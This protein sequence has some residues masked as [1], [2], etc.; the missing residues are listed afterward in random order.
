MSLPPRG[1]SCGRTPNIEFAQQSARI[2]LVNR[3]QPDTTAIAPFQDTYTPTG[4][5]KE[6]VPPAASMFWRPLFWASSG[7][8]AIMANYLYFGHFDIALLV[9]PDSASYLEFTPERTAGYPLFLRL[10]SPLYPQS[11]AVAQLNLYLAAVI[12]LGH[13]MLRLF[14][15]PWAAWLVTLMLAGHTSLQ[16]LAMW[17]LSDSLFASLTIAVLAAIAHL[18]MRP[19]TRWAV[20]ASTLCAA[21]ILVR[22]AG[23]YLFGVLIFLSITMPARNIRMQTALWVPVTASLVIASATNMVHFG[24]F[25]PQV[26]GGYSLVGHVAEKIESQPGGVHASLAESIA[27]RLRP[28]LE[29]RPV[30]PYPLGYQE[31]TTAD[32][33]EILWQNVIPEIAAYVAR[34]DPTKDA[35]VAT[36]AV[37]GELAR[38]VIR[39]H[40][41]WY[42][43]HVT[44]HFLGL[45]DPLLDD[46]PRVDLE[47]NWSAEHSNRLL[48]DSVELSLQGIPPSRVVDKPLPTL[49]AAVLWLLNLPWV[50]LAAYAVPLLIVL[51][52]ATVMLSLLSISRRTPLICFTA[53]LGLSAM[54][55]MLLVSSVQVALY[56][57]TLIAVPPTALLTLIGLATASS[58]L[59]KRL[60]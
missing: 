60:L 15:W 11:V 28:V 51:A 16:L 8:V 19:S 21:A 9:A 1:A 25:S 41:A 56:R 45:A 37:A 26:M 38:T 49:L 57:Y 39:T 6:A 30:A 23:Y 22:P 53:V 58:W 4:S 42:A 29:K 27:A 46:P 3:P 59:R 48:A 17:H 36:S 12:W 52:L 7:A 50:I 32:Y 35:Q 43:R 34:T 20:V 5:A 10:L 54:G 31:I 14:P 55:Y 24:V 47:I 13:S 18:L 40:P 44:A 33:N 2:V